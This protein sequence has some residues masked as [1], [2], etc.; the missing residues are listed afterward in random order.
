MESGERKKPQLKSKRDKRKKQRRRK[1]PQRLLLK[2]RKQRHS[3]LKRTVV[4]PTLLLTVRRTEMS[5]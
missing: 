2:L 1:K 3:Q 4:T 5:P